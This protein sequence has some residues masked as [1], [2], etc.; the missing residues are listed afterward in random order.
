MQAQDGTARARDEHGPDTA[1]LRLGGLVGR[2]PGAERAAVARSTCQRGSPADDRAA[3]ARTDTKH[4][5][6]VDA[7]FKRS[8]HP[9]I[10]TMLSVRDVFLSEPR[11]TECI[12]WQSP[13]FVYEGNIASIDPHAN[14]HVTVLFH[15]GAEIPA[16]IR[17][18]SAAEGPRATHGSPLVERS[19]RSAPH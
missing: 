18:S 16:S 4:D 14:E 1:A 9:L 19:P 2:E 10:D 5:A 11:V 17:C 12:K 15:R 8:S 3:M 7:W 13:T 6:A